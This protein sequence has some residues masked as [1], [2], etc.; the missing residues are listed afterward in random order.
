M[1]ERERTRQIETDRERGGEANRQ[2]REIEGS[3]ERRRE[4][5]E[6]GGEPDI[7]MGRAMSPIEGS[8]SHMDEHMYRAL[9]VDRNP[10]K[11]IAQDTWKEGRI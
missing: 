8:G 2:K 10:S 9:V 7:E 11:F 1:R 5:G 4:R 6:R 3:S